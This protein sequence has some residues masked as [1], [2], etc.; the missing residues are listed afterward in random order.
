MKNWILTI[1]FVS[2]MVSCGTAPDN[3]IHDQ[4]TEAGNWVL[5]PGAHDPIQEKL[6]YY[7]IAPT[8][9]QSVTWANERKDRV[10]TV[11]AAI[12][13]FIA[14]VALIIGKYTYASWFPEFLDTRVLLYNVLLFIS[15]SGAAYFYFG[16]ASGIKWNN[17]KWVKKELYDKCIKEIG[18]VQPIWDS[19]RNNCLIVNGPYDC[20]K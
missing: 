11:C 17:E 12:L 2:V 1:V 19:L 3:V 10:L 8:W 16:D 6:T 14:F 4:K 20:Y 13:L 9:G 7:Q 5:L 18:S 15:L